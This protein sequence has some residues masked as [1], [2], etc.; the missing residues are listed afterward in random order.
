MIRL[1]I[2]EDHP[3][4]GEGL[5]A[6]LAADPTLQVVGLARDEAGAA[7]LIAQSA[8]DVVLCD[9]MLGGRDA[10]FDLLAAHR[11]RC[12]FLLYSAFDLQGHR[13][14]RGL[15]PENSLPA[16]QRALEIGVTT[17]ELDIAVTKDGVLVEIGRAHV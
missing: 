7:A 12:A 11:D 5:A 2:V 1:L 4:M 14:A 13:G 6:L 9:V 15:L 10:G 16:F 8:P 3:A 17:L